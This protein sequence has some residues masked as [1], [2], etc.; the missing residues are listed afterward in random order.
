M[1]NFN[2]YV[3]IDISKDTFDVYSAKDGFSKFSNNSKGFISFLK[4]LDESYCCVMEAT[5][6]YHQLLAGFLFKHQVAVSVINPLVIKRYIQMKLHYTKTD[7]SD[8]KMIAGYAQEQEVSLWQPDPVYIDECKM[9]QSTIETYFK[10]STALKNRVHSLQSKGVIKGVLM[11]SLKR[12]L[13]HLKKE[14]LILEAE[15]ERLVKENNQ[16]LLTNIMT[17]PGVGKKTALLLITNTNAFK[18]FQ[19]HKQLSAYFGLAPREW[20]SGSSIRGRARITKAGAP[21]IRNH[22]FLCSFTACQY[23]PQCKAL[24]TRLVA[25][26][27]SKKL[28]L[29]AVANKLLKQTLAIAKSG[30]NYNPEYRSILPSD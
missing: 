20:T 3:G 17:I 30:V 9:L 5:G 14:I 2:H 1:N 24:Y 11:R 26:G 23:N 16:Q 15:L 18:Y 21:K 19:T 13:T 25:K 8:A 7:K 12:Q 4:T 28:A 27:K 10:Q 6:C 29:I 22:L